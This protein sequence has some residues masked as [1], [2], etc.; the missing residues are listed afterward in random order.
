PALRAPG[1]DPPSGTLTRSMVISSVIWIS[2]ADGEAIDLGDPFALVEAFAEM[3][4]AAESDDGWEE[5]FSVPTFVDYQDADA[6]WT[7]VRRRP[8]GAGRRGTRRGGCA[9][10][11]GTASASTRAGCWGSWGRGA[12]TRAA[13]RAIWRRE[14]NKA[15]GRGGRHPAPAPGGAR[16]RRPGRR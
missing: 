8:R 11:T 7:S 2:E 3:E 16:P 14:K 9:Q 12:G 13:T 4:Q 15:R 1:H 5:M 6:D 10:S